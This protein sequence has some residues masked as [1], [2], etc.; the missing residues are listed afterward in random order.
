MFRGV[1]DTPWGP[2]DEHRY[3]EGIDEHSSRTIVMF[4]SL[5]GLHLQSD[6]LPVVSVVP[7]VADLTE[8]LSPYPQHVPGHA[9]TP[10]RTGDG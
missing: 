4:R 9:L 3:D 6:V 7:V 5:S 2:T 8:R 10:F 1:G